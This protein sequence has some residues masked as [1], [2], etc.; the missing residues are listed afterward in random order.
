LYFTGLPCPESV[1]A[2]QTGP[3]TT[4]GAAFFDLDRTL[5]PVASPKIFQRHLSAAGFGT[6]LDGTLSD[7]AFKLFEIAGESAIVG[8]SAKLAPRAAVG[9]PVAEVVDAAGPAAD[10]IA[11]HVSDFAQ[12]ELA[13]HRAAGRSLVLATTTPEH[14]VRPLADRLGFD[15]VVATRWSQADGCFTGTVDGD[16]IWGPG[17]RD[18]V[19]EWCANR[20]V[21]LASCWAYSDSYYDSA[22]LDVVG[23][24]VAVNPDARLAATAALN[25][26]PIR[27]LD[28]PEGIPA[29]AGLELQDL[30][31]PFLRPELIPNANVTVRGVEHIPSTG[32]AIIVAN[33]RSE[34]DPLVMITTVARSGRNARYMGKREVFELPVIGPLLQA[35][36]GIPVDRGTGN[37]EPLQAAAAAIEGGDLVVMFPQGTIPRGRAFF[38]PVL[39]AR[40][41]AAR[42][43][44]M[45][46]APVIPVGLWGTDVVWPRSSSLPSFNLTDQPEVTSTVGAPVDLKYRSAAR[47]TER[48]MAA[49]TALLPAEARQPRE[50]TEEELARTYPSGRGD[51]LGFTE[52]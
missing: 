48:I 19:I 33:H 17:K 27:S 15:D 36:G 40:W 20:D 50:P 24:P 23:H 1:S 39:T 26:W 5:V 31:R 18:A 37:D 16:V 13:M 32:G 8:R 3:V 30:F 49:V 10:E 41:G 9:W 7:L 43:A 11:G 28:K 22:L 38:D 29:M 47:D 34:F 44:A 2:C 46:R 6:A 25:D 42:L 51:D 12:A 52:R 14:L 21:G 4:P 45:T 35:G